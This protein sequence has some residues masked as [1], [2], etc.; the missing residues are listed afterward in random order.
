MR[1]IAVVALALLLA[2]CSTPAPV[3]SGAPQQTPTPRPTLTGPVQPVGD[4]TVLA[5]D[6]TTPWS[7]VRLESGS[8]L[9]SERDLARVIELTEAGETLR[10]PLRAL[11]EW[12][13][14][15][16]GQVSGAWAE[17]DERVGAGAQG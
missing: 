2:G 8:T 13:I 7:L 12:S 16:F 11:E 15:H 1:R 14:A 6:L 4:A 10:G 5:T 3:P 17:Y 9:I